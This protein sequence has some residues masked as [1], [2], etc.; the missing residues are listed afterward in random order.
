MTDKQKYDKKR[1]GVLARAKPLLAELRKQAA[2]ACQTEKKLRSLVRVKYKLQHELSGC[3]T[4]SHANAKKIGI[5]GCCVDGNQ[6][7]A[8]RELKAM[9]PAC[10]G[11]EKGKPKDI[12]DTP[13][14]PE[15]MK[16]LLSAAKKRDS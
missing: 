5:T 9:A 13:N 8:F 12:P 14:L 7:K 10:P 11:Y 15:F 2:A 16:A 4:C 1:Q 3:R 6:A